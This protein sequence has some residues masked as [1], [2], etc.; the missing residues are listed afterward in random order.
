MLENY[1]ENGFTYIEL[2]DGEELWENRRVKNIIEAN[3]DVYMLLKKFYDNER[4]YFLW[5]NHD[6][7]KS[8]KIYANDKFSKYYNKKT[9]LKEE[10]F[11]DVN[12]HEALVLQSKNFK[13]DIFL[14][15]G[16]QV[17]FFNCGLWPLARFLARHLWKP[18]EYLGVQD[19]TRPRNNFV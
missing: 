17:D 3:I 12:I 1:Y 8:N 5:G 15:H 11:G 18:M 2:G 7:I 19:P 6:I 10:L 9:N 13:G 4:L 14:L 16:H